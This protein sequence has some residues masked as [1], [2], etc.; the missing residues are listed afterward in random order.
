MMQTLVAVNLAIKQILNEN[1][2]FFKQSPNERKQF[3]II[4]IGT[5]T[6]KNEE[7][8]NAEIAA[9]WGKLGWILQIPSFSTPIIDVFSQAGGDMVDFHLSTVTHVL[10]SRDTYLR[11]QVIN[12]FS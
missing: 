6:T 10:H 12:Y 4:S 1:P 8:F 7:K 2:D 11:I 5:G 9:K 3:L